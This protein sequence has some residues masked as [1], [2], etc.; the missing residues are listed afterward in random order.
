ML[1]PLLTIQRILKTFW[2]HLHFPLLCFLNLLGYCKNHN[3]WHPRPVLDEPSQVRM[4]WL[5]YRVHQ[6]RRDFPV[7]PILVREQVA[8]RSGG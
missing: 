3:D 1:N 5:G 6:L 7:A 4:E 2:K 8:R